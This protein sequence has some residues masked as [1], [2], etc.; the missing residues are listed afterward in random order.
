MSVVRKYQS[1]GPAPN[2]N[3]YSDFENFLAEK[4]NKEA[5]RNAFTAKG[6]Q[7]VRSQASL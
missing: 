7:A 2:K 6:E 3:E 1:G 5:S 4:I